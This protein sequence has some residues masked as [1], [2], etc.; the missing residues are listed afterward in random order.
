[1][2]IQVALLA[3]MLALSGQ[4]VAEEQAESKNAEQLAACTQMAE[5]NGLQGEE[6]Q[7]FMSECMESAAKK[8]GDA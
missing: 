8:D 7:N 5:D 6:M 4:V 2:K 3:A 1:M